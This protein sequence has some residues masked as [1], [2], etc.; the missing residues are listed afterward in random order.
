MCVITSVLYG[1]H[2]TAIVIMWAPQLIGACTAIVI[3][4]YSHSTAI[5][6]VQL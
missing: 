2:S 4:Q 6:I 3:V 5:V 1:P